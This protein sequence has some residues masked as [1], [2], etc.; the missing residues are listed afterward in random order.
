MY[1]RTYHASTTVAQ[2]QQARPAPL[3]PIKQP[4]PSSLV[5]SRSPL[6]QLAF[7]LTYTG[8][9]VCACYCTKVYTCMYASKPKPA[10]PC[11]AIDIYVYMVYVRMHTQ[12]ASPASISPSRPSTPY[13]WFLGPSTK[14]RD[15]NRSDTDE[16]HSYRICFHIYVRIRIRIRI[17]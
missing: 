10:P 14:S 11:K 15:E 16:Y 3:P 7:L 4:D 17:V 13:P 6:K 5:N 1:T 12:A 2:L 8:C 9:S